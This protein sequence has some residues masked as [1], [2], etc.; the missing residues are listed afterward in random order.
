MVRFLSL[1]F[2]SVALSAGLAHL[3]ALPNKIQFSREDYLVAQQIYRG[4]ALLG[5]A[6]FGALLFT[7]ILTIA[8]RHVPKVFELTLTALVCI[9]ASLVV[10]FLFTYPANEVTRNWTVLPDGWRAL[11]AQWEYSHAAGAGLYLI[12]M[13]ALIWSLLVGPDAAPIMRDGQTKA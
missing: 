3:F 4:W 10:F 1:L 8:V 11:R 13:M 2:T 7:L 6:I 12:A 9:A 5:I